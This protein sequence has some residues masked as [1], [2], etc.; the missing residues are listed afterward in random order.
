MPGLGWAKDL[1]ES[2]AGV[3][4]VDNRKLKDVERGFAIFGV[5]TAGYGSKLLMGGKIFK[6]LGNVPMLAGFVKRSQKV[7]HIFESAGKVGTLLLTK[8]SKIDWKIAGRVKGQLADSRMGDLA[9]KISEKR[10]VELLNNPQAK[11]YMDMRP[12]SVTGIPNY[13][14]NIIQEIEGKFVRI[15]V[16]NNEFKIISV[17]PIRANSVTNSIANGKFYPLK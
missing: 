3:G 9:G 7:G 2:V 11:R 15:T 13:H 10:L 1:Y 4:M 8:F 12:N 17:G 14:I 6:A 16:P 5:V